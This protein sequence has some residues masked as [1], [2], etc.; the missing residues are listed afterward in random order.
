[1]IEKQNWFRRPIAGLCV[2]SAMAILSAFILI[3]QDQGREKSGELSCMVTQRHY[4]VDAREMERT[5]AIP[6]EDALS[7]IPGIKSVLTLSENSQVRAYARFPA[8]SMNRGIYD[9]IREAAQ[10]VYETLPSSAQRPEFNS[11][12]ETG[13]PVWIAAVLDF[14]SGDYLEKSVKPVFEGIEG[15]ARVEISGTGITEIIIAPDP[16]KSAAL[17]LSPYHIAAS[18]GMN[19]ALFTAGTIR[20]REKDIL[21]TVDGRYSDLVSLEKALVPLERG[22]AVQLKDLGKIYESEREGD[23]LSRLDGK[24]TAVISIISASGTD[25]GT[26]SRQ[27]KKKIDRFSASSR[28]AEFSS[29]TPGM[30]FHVLQDRGAEEAAALRSV[31]IAALE[32]SVLVALTAIFLVRKKDGNIFPGLVCAAAIPLISLISAALLSCL[33]FSL[34]RKLLAGLSVGIGAAAD[35]VLIA[36]QGYSGIKNTREGGKI[37]AKIA[38]PLISGAATT[39]AALFPLASFSEA[40]G[41]NVIAWALGAV[42]MVSVAVSLTI[43]PP[44]LLWE[45]KP[46]KIFRKYKTPLIFANIRRRSFRFLALMIRFLLKKTFLI[47]VLALL[48]SIA[49]LAALLVKGTDINAGE[50]ENSVYA[51]VEFEGGF[52]KEEGDLLMT[53][54]AVKLKEKEGI[55]AIQSSARVGSGQIL[56]NFDSG[57]IK[58]SEVRKLIRTPG[59]PGGF[60]F[61]P[62]PSGDERIWEIKISGD[63]DVKCRE[64]AEKAAGL[65]STLPLIREVVLNFKEG[66]PGLSVNPRREELAEGSVSFAAAADTLRRGIYGPVIYK[67]IGERGETD[68]RL[69]LSPTPEKSPL[70]EDIMALPVL[71]ANMTG[72]NIFRIDSLSTGKRDT[73]PSVIRRD[74]RRRVASLS[75]RTK[76]IDPRRVRDQVF[77]VLKKLELPP[78]YGIEFDP[79]AIRRAEAL[80]GTGI[81]FLLALLFCYMVMAAAN[82]SLGFPLAVLAAVPPSLAVPILVLTLSGTALNGA[83]ACSLVA[84][85]GMTV[86]ASIVVMAEFRR[87]DPSSGKWTA[88]DIYKVLR[89]CFSI[90]LATSSTTMAGALPFLFLKEGGNSILRD[91]SMVTIFGVGA[92]WICSLVLIPSI[93]VLLDNRHG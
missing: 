48:I 7:A 32:A 44:L 46:D 4:G 5:I 14:P 75:V 2:F 74:D 77:Q 18:L 78:G 21:V 90:L 12:D 91:L 63:D 83:L 81:R 57:K 42:T 38:A 37:L 16:E 3:N 28:D 31:L 35:A 52:R 10:R 41:I 33:G 20:T 92:S 67:R 62:E 65:C 73:E 50:S 27:I 87:T 51:R 61:I 68:V 93:I 40:A 64:L 69:R 72:R 59:I 9:A 71:S 23:S 13:I 39:M 88:R 70:A 24:K 82:E 17:G 8:N 54:W 43:L 29:G 15:V 66:N 58:N 47:P 80:S 6:L 34:D 19:D 56:V 11:S 79:E 89:H 30:R 60:I 53:D 55:L 22:G 86:N 36:A 26:L 49:A 84:V 45:K 1:M 76:L 85:S 25:L